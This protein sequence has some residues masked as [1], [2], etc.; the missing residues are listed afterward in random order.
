MPS[1]QAM[2]W[3]PRLPCTAID[4]ARRSRPAWGSPALG[5]VS[6]MLIAVSHRAQRPVQAGATR[7]APDCAVTR[8]PARSLVPLRRRRCA[9]GA[10]SSAGACTRRRI[11][12]GI[13]QPDRAYRCSAAGRFL[14]GVTRGCCRTSD[15]HGIELALRDRIVLDGLRGVLRSPVLQ[16]C[17]NSSSSI[18]AI[19][20]GL[21]V[22]HITLHALAERNA[23]TVR[24]T[25]GSFSGPRTMSAMSTRSAIDLGE[26]DVEHCQLR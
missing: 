3:C 7:A 21:D 9:A 22:V 4:P 18:D 26:A 11:G 8:T 15:F 5:L 25:R 23:Q 13:G 20:V 10:S 1:R 16:S 14:R 24:A 2:P 19:D 6:L 17:F 12:K